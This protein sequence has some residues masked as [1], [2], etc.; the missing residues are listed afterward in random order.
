MRS[1]PGA[2]TQT[3]DDF[4]S[5]K[6]NMTNKKR[7]IAVIF[8]IKHFNDDSVTDRK[9]SEQHDADYI[10]MR[11][12]LISMRFEIKDMKPD[13]SMRQIKSAMAEG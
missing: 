13:M 3:S 5:Y 10:S 8:N 11:N 7:G 1:K 2:G 12:L 9:F 6:Y 4:G